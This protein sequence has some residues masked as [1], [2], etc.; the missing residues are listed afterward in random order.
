M[1]RIYWA[2]MEKYLKKYSPDVYKTLAPPAAD[3]QVDKLIKMAELHIPDSFIQSLLIHDGQND[4]DRLFP[5]FDYQHI[6]SCNQ[7]IST[8]N[9]YLFIEINQWSFI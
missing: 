6:L 4:E 5:L 1:I 7:I 8:Y 2:V 3:S 9:G